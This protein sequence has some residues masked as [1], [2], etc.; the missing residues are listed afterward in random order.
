MWC[1]LVSQLYVVCLMCAAVMC[2]TCVF[3]VWRELWT[4]P[5]TGQQSQLH[6][7]TG[8]CS[9]LS[10]VNIFVSCKLALF[11]RSCPI[12]QSHNVA[13]SFYTNFAFST[14]CRSL[15]NCQW[16]IRYQCECPQNPFSCSFCPPEVEIEAAASIKLSPPNTSGDANIQF[17]PTPK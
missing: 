15:K 13:Q 9:M 14:M 12:S 16:G 3:D 4:L 5:A 6:C 11:L 2:V 8:G 17:L 1:G 7:V 10:E